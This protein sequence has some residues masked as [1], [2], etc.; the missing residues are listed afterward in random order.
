M[1]RL[2][3][4]YE[5]VRPR[6]GVC[7]GG[8]GRSCGGAGRTAHRL[9]SCGAWGGRSAAVAALIAAAL[10]LWTRVDPV[11]PVRLPL[12]VMAGGV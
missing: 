10:I 12:L 1:Q 4:G 2:S 6:S 11:D 8:A 9:C 3:Q 5:R 7:A